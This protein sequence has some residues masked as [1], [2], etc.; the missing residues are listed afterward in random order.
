[1]LKIKYFFPLLLVIDVH[2][3]MVVVNKHDTPRRIMSIITMDYNKRLA[4][5]WCLNTDD[6]PLILEPV[7]VFICIFCHFR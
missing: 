1:M 6:M 5:A 4:C 2:R 7:H 3:Y